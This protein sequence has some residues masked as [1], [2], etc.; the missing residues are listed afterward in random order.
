MIDPTRIQQVLLNLVSNAM[1][2]TPHGT[3]TLYAGV[4]EDQ[5]L[6]GVSDT[7]EGI[8]ADKLDSVFE[9]FQQLDANVTRRQAGSGLGLA[10]SRELVEMHGGQIWAESKVGVGTDFKFVLPLTALSESN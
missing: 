7:G 6:I 1:K 10:I 3:V 2:F 8:P 9:R 5:V 4:L